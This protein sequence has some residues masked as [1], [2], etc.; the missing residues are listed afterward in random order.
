MRDLIEIV[1]EIKEI[2]EEHIVMEDRLTALKQAGIDDI[3]YRYLRSGE[4]VITPSSSG[5]YA[6]RHLP[7]KF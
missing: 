3:E 4:L 7:K 6:T 5:L 2:C 1:T